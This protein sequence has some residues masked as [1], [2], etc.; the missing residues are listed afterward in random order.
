MKPMATDFMAVQWGAVDRASDP[1]DFVRYLDTVSELET[2]RCI[3]QRTFDLL[4]VR[5]GDRLLDV[6]CGTGE[7][8][9]ALA[10]RV[11]ATG[12]VVGVDPS[13]SMLAEARSR[14]REANLPIEFRVG[15]AERLEF[16]DHEFDGCRAERV[17]MH[18]N[19]P[20]RSLAE[21]VR[22]TRPGGRI[23]VSD[24]DWETLIVDAPD[25]ETTRKLSNFHCDS[26]GSR[27]IGRQLRRLFCEAGLSHI[28]V[29]ADTLVFTDYDQADVVFQ[30]RQIAVQ[31][32]AAR[33]VSE[34]QANG[35]LDDLERAQQRGTFFAAVSGFCVSGSK[36]GE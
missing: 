15:S 35:W 6:G 17:F 23:V 5:E 25:R 26:G 3:K 28:A 13:H 31:A 8:V 12:R 1:R 21:M 33:V 36:P 16:E 14:V 20:E 2:I 18:L 10:R 27:W 22:V 7:D 11:G 4:G 32:T 24:R 30:L 19:D 29:I 9:R 34:P